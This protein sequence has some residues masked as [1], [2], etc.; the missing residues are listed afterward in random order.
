M[1]IPETS[2]VVFTSIFCPHL[3]STTSIFHNPLPRMVWRGC[4]ALFFFLY[5]HNLSKTFSYTIL[6][7]SVPCIFVCNK[8]FTLIFTYIKIIHYICIYFL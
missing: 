6:K 5:I 7:L 4:H 1:L 2:C 3:P 8:L